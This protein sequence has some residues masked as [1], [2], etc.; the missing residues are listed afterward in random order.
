MLPNA[1]EEGR[2]KEAQRSLIRP[3]SELLPAQEVSLA[4]LMVTRACLDGIEVPTPE[5]S[6]A[7]M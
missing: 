3:A 1:Q 5:C 6:A 2:R 7:L 4:A